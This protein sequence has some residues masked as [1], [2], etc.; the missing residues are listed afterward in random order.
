MERIC[1]KLVNTAEALYAHRM[2]A[3]DIY[4]RE[5]INKART[6]QPMTFKNRIGRLAL[7]MRKTKARCSDFLLGNTLEDTIALVNIKLSDQES[8]A[9]NNRLRSLKAERANDF[10]GIAKDAKWPK[11][12]D[13]EPALFPFLHG[14]VYGPAESVS[15]G[16]MK[17]GH[18]ELAGGGEMQHAADFHQP[19]MVDPG[20]P[21]Y[22]GSLQ[23]CTLAP[24]VA[25]QRGFGLSGDLEPLHV[26]FGINFPTTDSRARGFSG[27]KGLH[28]QTPEAEMHPGNMHVFPDELHASVPVVPFHMGPA[29]NGPIEAPS[30]YSAHV[31]DMAMI[32]GVRIPIPP[33]A[34]SHVV[35]QNLGLG[36]S[37]LNGNQGAMFENHH[38][39]PLYGPF[40]QDRQAFVAATAGDEILEVDR[41]AGYYKFSRPIRRT[42][43]EIGFL[44]NDGGEGEGVVEPTNRRTRGGNAAAGSGAA[45]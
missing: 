42:A 19:Y 2:G 9:A 22:P 14:P 10:C 30:A 39:Y 40:S 3:T 44:E 8:N 41:S 32:K 35:Y 18:D 31:V 16:D 29:F 24:P 43:Q 33:V 27:F 20:A 17:N 7:L 4:C 11:D 28:G 21:Q 1:R 37:L 25:H 34:M 6:A 45:S 13:G 26:N 12:E 5:T 38:G 36:A 23:D 15:P